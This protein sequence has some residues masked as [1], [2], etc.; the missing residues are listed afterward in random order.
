MRNINIVQQSNILQATCVG[1]DK[2]LNEAL[3]LM[4]ENVRYVVCLANDQV[5]TVSAMEQATGKKLK[6]VQSGGYN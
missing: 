5:G 4:E 1:Q 6:G 2:N 3:D